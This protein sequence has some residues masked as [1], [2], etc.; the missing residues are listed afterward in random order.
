[1]SHEIQQIDTAKRRQW[2]LDQRTKGRTYAEIADAAQEKFDALPNGYDRRYVWKDVQRSLQKN[3]DA[4]TRKAKTYVELS[5]RRLETLLRNVWDQT[6]EHTVTEI[7]S[8]GD[9]IEVEVPPDVQAVREAR[10]LVVQLLKTAVPDEADRRPGGQQDGE[11]TPAAQ[12]ET[13][14]EKIE[15][16][17]ERDTIWEN[18]Q[19]G[20]AHG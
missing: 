5:I 1:M 17:I 8:D 2:V 11:E 15:R 18:G 4:V 14:R 3:K 12:R 19:N 13:I 7:S 20:A 10:E 6:E 16:E 9:T